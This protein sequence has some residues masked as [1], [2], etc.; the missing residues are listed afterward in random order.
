MVIFQSG[1]LGTH[2]PV[3]ELLYGLRL[4][5]RVLD[6]VTTFLPH[7]TTFDSS[8]HHLIHESHYVGAVPLKGMESPLSLKLFTISLL[9]HL[10]LSILYQIDATIRHVEMLMMVTFLH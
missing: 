8:S 5:I 6:L 4:S 10:T 1:E 3:R 2:I 7:Q 9:C